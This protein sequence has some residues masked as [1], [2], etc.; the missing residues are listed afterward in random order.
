MKAFLQTLHVLMRVGNM[1]LESSRR[2]RHFGGE[3]SDVTLQ[4]RNES[5]F[6]C[7]GIIEPCDQLI[8][9]RG[10]WHC[11]APAALI[12]Q[13]LCRHIGDGT[14]RS[15]VRAENGAGRPVSCCAQER[16]PQLRPFKP[17]WSKSW[18]TSLMRR[19]S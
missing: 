1:E 2:L 18:L 3:M 15:N 9:R 12:V 4:D 8:G 14:K 11:G 6:H 19:T 7:M 13:R 5:A 10:A 17:T 16:W